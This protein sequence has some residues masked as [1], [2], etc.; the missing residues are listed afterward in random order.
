MLKKIFVASGL[1][2][3][4]FILVGCQT[5]VTEGPK[6][7]VKEIPEVVYVPPTPAQLRLQFES[8]FLD[9]RLN[10]IE[11]IATDGE[12]IRLE[13]AAGNEFIMTILLDDIELTD[14]NLASHILSFQL[15]FSQM[16]ELFGGLAHNI[17]YEADLTHFRLTVVFIDVA[18]VEI[19]RSNFDSGHRNPAFTFVVDDEDAVEI[20]E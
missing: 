11:S 10:I 12:D 7:I 15:T 19:A 6:L 9:N 3:F 14:E 16:S 13:I 5:E 8:F 17:R 4:S 2:F 18:G 20:D 1:L